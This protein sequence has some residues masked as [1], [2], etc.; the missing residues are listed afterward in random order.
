MILLLRI[1]LGCLIGASLYLTFDWICG[2]RN[3]EYMFIKCFIAF[4]LGYCF[5]LLI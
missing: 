1:Y 3:D 2:T 4:M 5:D